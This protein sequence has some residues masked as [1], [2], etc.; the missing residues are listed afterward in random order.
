M[1]RI[2]INIPSVP[3]TATKC[4]FRCPSSNL[5]RLSRYECLDIFIKTNIFVKYGTRVCIKHGEGKSL[6]IPN[7]FNSSQNQLFLSSSEIASVINDF[8]HIIVNERLRE[9]TGESFLEMPE[10]KT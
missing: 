4:I 10:K 6:Q 1:S 9:N 7:D 3:S 8:K 2:E 5:R